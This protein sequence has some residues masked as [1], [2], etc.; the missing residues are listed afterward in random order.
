MFRK[1]S[2]WI[3]SRN[4]LMSVAGVLVALLVV[5]GAGQALHWWDLGSLLGTAGVP[6]GG[7]ACLPTCD[8]T[9]GKFLSMPS[10]YMASFAGITTTVWI[11]AP[12]GSSS[13]KI[14]IFDGD[15][16]KNNAGELD[17]YGDAN[18]DEVDTQAVYRLYADPY[19]DGINM[20]EIG[21]WYGND[22]N[23]TS[24]EGWSA[25]AEF[26][27][28]NAW[29]DI[30]IQNIDAARGPDGR[31]YYRFE[32]NRSIEGQGIVVFKLR[33]EGD[34][35][36]GNAEEL[37]DAQFAV[38]GLFSTI[39]DIKT[40]YPQFDGTNWDNLGPST[41]DGTWDFFF[42]VP[43]GAKSLTI[44]DADF[45]RG[46]APDDTSADTDDFNTVDKPE[47]AGIDAVNERAGKQGDPADDYE[48]NVARREPPVYY[49]I[50]APDGATILRNVEPSGTEEWEKFVIGR[51]DQRGEIEADLYVDRILPGLYT[52]K[53]VG[54]DVHN[55]VWFRIQHEQGEICPPC[56]D[57]PDCTVPTVEPTPE[58]T[59]TPEPTPVPTPEPCTEI[60]APVDVLYVMDVS[61]SMDM[62]YP[63]ERTGTKLEAAKQAI[64]NTN[65]WLAANAGAG[66]RV[67]LM[68]YNTVSLKDATKA[69]QLQSGFTGNTGE[70][71]AIVDGLKAGGWT[72]T[73]DAMRQA[74]AWMP[75]AWDSSHVPVVILLSDGVPTIDFDGHTF[76]QDAVQ[77]THIYN[78]D[79]SAK[80]IDEVRASG[81]VA[82]TFN[83]RAG[84]PLADVMVAVG[85]FKAALPSIT[86]HTI[87]IQAAGREGVFNDEILR[88][89]A[90]ELGGQF[91]TSQDAETLQNALQAAILV[92]SCGTTPGGGDTPP[93]PTPEPGTCTN[94]R[95]NTYNVENTTRNPFYGIK[96]NYTSGTEIKGGAYDEFTF[97]LTKAQAEGMR[98]M[99]LEAKAA[100]AQEQVTLRGCNFSQPTPC[101]TVSTRRYAFTFLGATDN[102]DGTLTLTFKVENGAARGLS[103]VTFGLP[104]GVKPSQP[105]SGN[106]QTEVCLD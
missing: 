8:E 23:P 90:A 65:A 98:S 51:E 52:M 95:T 70:V 79:G 43:L 66:S 78:A 20:T 28:N 60:K 36:T 17:V 6:S 94:L 103:H 88:Y 13:F 56:P 105:P 68:T 53:I 75:G 83:E 71:D 99:E 61:A 1:F 37:V 97:V 82:N 26:M 38:V 48:W 69:I 67:A 57:C 9:D 12:D 81:K 7:Y 102:G 104:A 33:T 54:L 32:A 21:Q 24:G 74:T 101:A 25:S 80:T 3:R 16:G 76:N 100:T 44:W 50:I 55:T 49:D 42:D 19:K 45:D 41:Y 59:A 58:P 92:S 73:G 77:K 14:G 2:R 40:L 89:A 31:Y 64:K 11:K 34:L 87:A 62:L 86:G 4:G 29:Y 106:Y 91:Y 22:A 10:Q 96:F 47:W 84:D 63:G 27:P 5:A 72:P 46:A 15:S 30:T 93:G 18:W 35:M 39:N 85:E